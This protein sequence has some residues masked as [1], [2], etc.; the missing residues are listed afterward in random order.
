MRRTGRGLPFRTGRDHKRDGFGQPIM[1]LF[2]LDLTA[3]SPRSP[4]VRLGGYVCL[5]RLLDKGRAQLA[6]KA[7]DYRYHC[8]IDRR[9][10]SFTGV[11]AEALLAEM[12]KEKSDGEMLAWIT[13]NAPIRRHPSEIAAWSAYMEARAPGDAESHRI[14]AENLQ[15]LAPDREDIA[16]WFDL[17]DL[18]DYVSFGGR[19]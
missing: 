3:R 7:G 18:D 17:L 6:G 1:A 2:F 10:F 11:C 19:A 16:T 5:P 15:K 9:W 13:E 8:P 14:F 12:A 4:R